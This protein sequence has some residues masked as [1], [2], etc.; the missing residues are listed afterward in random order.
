M[1]AAEH[2]LVN[3]DNAADKG[4]NE[5]RAAYGADNVDRAVDH[6]ARRGVEAGYHHYRRSETDSRRSKDGDAFAAANGEND[7]KERRQSR[8]AEG[9]RR[10]NEPCVER[11][12]PLGPGEA[13]VGFDKAAQRVVAGEDI[14]YSF[15]RDA[16]LKA[17]FGQ[18]GGRSEK[19]EVE[20]EN[21][22]EKQRRKN[23]IH[24]PIQ[25]FHLG[26]S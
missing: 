22:G 9:D 25:I 18:R 24:Y 12:K 19:D 13:L 23:Y 2:Q 14:N 6:V 16:L 7:D 15:E 5:A 10:R 4:G 20:E 1:E 3:A 17:V 26:A 21:G 8:N 11:G